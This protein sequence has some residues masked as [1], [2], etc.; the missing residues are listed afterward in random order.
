M[1]AHISVDSLRELERAVLIHQ[2][3]PK[4]TPAQRRVT[5]LGF[6][7]SL[8]KQVTPARGHTCPTVKRSAYDRLRPPTSPT[9]ATLVRKYGGWAKV[10]FRGYGLEPDGSHWGPSQPWLSS[11]KGR[12]RTRRYIVEDAVT[13]IRECADDVGK[14]PTIELYR[15]W[16]RGKRSGAHHGHL[17]NP[18]PSDQTIYGLF[19]EKGGWSGLLV[20]AELITWD[21]C[22]IW[23]SVPSP[24]AANGL[25]EFLR[26]CGLVA[27]MRSTRLVCVRYGQT[28]RE[29][30]GRRVRKLVAAWASRSGGRAWQEL[31]PLS[32]GQSVRAAERT[33][34][35]IGN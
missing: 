3:P 10:C 17:S 13:A 2:R 26:G 1:L 33:G 9:S 34:F 5:E 14:V 12:R 27:Y 7:A 11:G 22:E 6:L 8:L 15:A 20:A 32:A 30:E 23:M 29:C 35:L 4:A 31:D 19:A 25:I 21:P 24:I 16:V 18:P 28:Y